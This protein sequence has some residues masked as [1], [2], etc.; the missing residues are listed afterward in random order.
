MLDVWDAGETGIR[1]ERS[2]QERAPYADHAEGF[3][4]TPGGREVRHFGPEFDMRFDQETRVATGWV[5]AD[6]VPAWH[7]L[8]PWQR[9][10]VSAL[11]GSGIESVHAA[12]VARDGR[13]VLLP[14]QNGAGKSS[15]TFA[16][17]AAGLR[18]LGDDAIAVELGDA[19]PIGNTVHAVAKLSVDGL[20]RF[21]E[22][23][24]VSERHDDPDAEERAIRLAGGSPLVARSASVSA[25]AFPRLVDSELSAVHPLAPVRAATELFG[26]SL[27]LEPWRVGEAFGAL[28][29]LAAQAPA[30]TLE[31]GRDPA[32]L[33][34]TVAGL[35]AA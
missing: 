22:L 17:L 2:A 27:S 15:T 30:F 28:S 13:G 12:M 14:G 6:R 34:E 5:A 24:A 10:F 8:R 29:D 33:A 16:C 31:V 21:P 25:I 19:P 35:L 23:A 11:A 7:R 4:Y 32:S 20:A 26:A 9:V 1:P 3:V 18:F